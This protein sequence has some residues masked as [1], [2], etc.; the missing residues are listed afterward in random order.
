MVYL[1]VHWVHIFIP[2]GSAIRYYLNK[3]NDEKLFSFWNNSSL[4][5]REPKLNE[6]ITLKFFQEQIKFFLRLLL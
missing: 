3:K 5:K 2:M 6:E 4:F 1:L